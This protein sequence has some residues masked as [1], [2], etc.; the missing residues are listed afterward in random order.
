VAL[1]QS[2]L[3]GGVTALGW[4][5]LRVVGKVETRLHRRIPP[6]PPEP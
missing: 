3:A 6:V 5:T 4:L 1:G 2:I